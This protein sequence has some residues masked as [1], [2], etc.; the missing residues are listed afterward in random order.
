MKKNRA[1]Y[2]YFSILFVALTIVH[3][4]HVFLI[5]H[6]DVSISFFFF[7]HAL[8]QSFLESVLFLFGAT[9]IQS[10]LSRIWTIIYMALTLLIFI[11]HLVDF[12]LVRLL[13][14]SIWHAL[15][16][17]SQETSQNFVEML[18]A[19]NVSL[20]T[21]ALVAIGG[22]LFLILG[23]FCSYFTEKLVDRYPVRHL[24]RYLVRISCFV[25]LCL[26]GLDQMIDKEFFAPTYAKFYK[27]LPWKGILFPPRLEEISICMS[28]ELP[29]DPSLQIYQPIEKSPPVFVFVIESLREDYIQA[30]VAP[31]LT[32]FKQEHTSFDAAFANANATNPGWFSLFYSQYPFYW[33]N[34][35][36]AKQKIGSSF[37]HAF[38]QMG[39]KTHVYSATRL[40]FYQMDQLLFGEKRELANEI[41]SF[42]H[43]TAELIYKAD[44]LAVEK[45]ISDF[46]STEDSNGNLYIVFLDGTHFGYS[47]P[48]ENSPFFPY[49]DEL[50]YLKI[51]CRQEKIEGIQNR[52]RNAIHYIDSLFGKFINELKN[53]P[54]W[55]DA[56][57]VVT[58]DHGEEFEENG[59]I[60]HASEPNCH[61]TH[62]PIYYKF[63][64]KE[65]LPIP[66][67]MTS[68]V[69]VLP[70]LLHY[71]TKQEVVG[72]AGESIF[73]K[74]KAPFVVSTRYNAC[75]NPYEFVINNGRYK[76]Y[77]QFSNETDIFASKWLRVV[78]TRDLDEERITLSF[79]EQL[80]EFQEAIN[81]IFKSR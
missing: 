39:Y 5:R 80:H 25:L 29:Q 47:W 16:F 56:V 64:L 57:V 17:M 1:N 65:K 45:L 44:T 52:Y 40:S 10:H 77:A 26:A 20:T 7:A 59:H 22:G 42:P 41:F 69:D 75:L 60:F 24:C 58:A 37:A 9:Y 43:D 38:K 31:Y 71:L 3:G 74:N 68:Q 6:E 53:S 14:I 32:Q 21:Y 4:Y 78:E 19:S 13:D 76:L 28:Q 11:G 54:Q 27:A 73:T 15:F 48:K 79:E 70:T 67:K 23:A 66:C 36:Y 50:N 30:D 62:I 12:S 2:F 8:G 34:Y 51:A 72:F 61:Q 18:H 35:Y 81:Q 46:S 33:E 55:E 63:G 49:S